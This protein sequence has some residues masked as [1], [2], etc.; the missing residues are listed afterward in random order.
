MK[1]DFVFGLIILSVIIL[2]VYV[3][4]KDVPLE[5]NKEEGLG[6]AELINRVK[7]EL[8]LTE[9]DGSAPMFKVKNF[10]LEINFIVKS[11]QKA[12]G[13]FE[14]KVITVGGETEASNE[15]VQKITLRMAALETHASQD[16]PSDID[17]NIIRTPLRTPPPSKEK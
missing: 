4:K 15:K 11:R 10:D 13:G 1:I 3:H 14:Y 7:A 5:E 12:Q 16:D 6:V 8:M 2:A 17:P 9:K